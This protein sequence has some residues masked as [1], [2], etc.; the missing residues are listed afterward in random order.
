MTTSKN[1]RSLH[2]KSADVPSYRDTKE[3]KVKPNFSYRPLYR[4]AYHTKELDHYVRNVRALSRHQRHLRSRAILS[5]PR[6]RLVGRVTDAPS[7]WQRLGS[8][9]MDR[10]L[11]GYLWVITGLGG[12]KP[13]R[14]DYT[15]PQGK[16]G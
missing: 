6:Q 15:V 1:P 4:N 14:T 13:D 3:R 11:I 9:V 2:H 7:W 16:N 12:V 10:L 8:W 5:T